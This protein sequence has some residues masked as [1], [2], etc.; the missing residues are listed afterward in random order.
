MGRGM[1][2]DDGNIPPPIFFSVLQK[3]KRAVDGP[4]E[5]NAARLRLPQNRHASARGVVY[6]GMSASG[7]PACLHPLALARRARR[8]GSAGEIKKRG[9]CVCPRFFSMISAS[10]S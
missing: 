6:A 7:Y 1:G 10:L 2:H 5:K 9:R 3:R 8:G 4:K